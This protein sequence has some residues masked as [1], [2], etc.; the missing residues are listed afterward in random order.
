MSIIG[1]MDVAESKPVYF[2]FATELGM[3]TIVT[4]AVTI[5]LL[6]GTD[7]APDGMRVGSPTVDNINRM[8]ALQL[9]PVDRAGNSY[10]LRCRA[11]DSAGFSHVISCTLTVSRI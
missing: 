3:N 5:D 9:A 6:S 8:V 2:P 7:A 1:P 11:V 10:H 4:A